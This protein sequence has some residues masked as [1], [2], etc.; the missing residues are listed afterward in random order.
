MVF[1]YSQLSYGDL[2]NHHKDPSEKN[3]IQWK[4]RPCFFVK[5]PKFTKFTTKNKKDTAQ[6]AA[7]GQRVFVEPCFGGR[8]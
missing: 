3:R 1:L 6:K 4:V 7:I 5:S 2:I 8:G